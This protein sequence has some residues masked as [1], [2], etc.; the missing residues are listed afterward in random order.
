MRIAIVGSRN[1]TVEDIGKYL[2]DGVCEIVSGGAKGVDSCAAQYAK[3]NKIPLKEFLPEYEKYGRAAP[4][5]RN[6]QIVQ[7]ADCVIVFWDGESKGTLS[8]IKYCEKTEK[9][10]TVLVKDKTLSTFVNMLKKET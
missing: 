10:C 7:Y 1:L 9:R 2:P 5:V 4:I 8:V 3:A 6:R